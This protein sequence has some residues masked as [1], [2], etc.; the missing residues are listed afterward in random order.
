MKI[1]TVTPAATP[2]VT[3]AQVRDHLRLDGDDEQDWIEAAIVTAT[4][5]AETALQ[6]SLVT[7]TLRAT[8][9]DTE[10]MPQPLAL[11]RGPVVSVVEVV[12]RDGFTVV[13]DDYELR[14]TGTSDYLHF[15]RGQSYPLSVEY[16]AGF[17]DADDVPQSIKHAIMLHVAWLYNQREAVSD[18]P[19]N[20]VALG[21]Q[22]IYQQHM[23]GGLL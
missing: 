8:W 17:G 2:P 7:R 20:H 5:Y 22:A 11:P 4:E 18:R 15:V 16:T 6:R 13:P 12:D 10:A 3:Y 21:L 1:E 9:Y 19:Q 14:R 23:G